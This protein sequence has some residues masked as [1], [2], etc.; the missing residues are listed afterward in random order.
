MLKMIMARM[1]MKAYV[2]LLDEEDDG[3]SVINHVL[4]STV[5]KKDC[6]IKTC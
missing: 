2:N 3:C 1:M 5:S 6:V 4:L